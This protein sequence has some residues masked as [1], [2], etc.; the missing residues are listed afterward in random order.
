[1]KQAGFIFVFALALLS[2]AL[3][4]TFTVY[5]TRISAPVSADGLADGETSASSTNL[6]SLDANVYIFDGVAAPA[7]AVVV[8]HGFAESKDTL[9]IGAFAEDFAA[10]GYVVVTPSVRGFGNSDGLVSLVGPNEIN[11]LKSIILAMQTGSIGDSPAV[12][13][14]VTSQSKF[15]VMGDSYGRAHIL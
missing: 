10:A 8:V 3:G 12:V 9:A 14:P 4:G 11:D 7:P 13:I 5:S 1:M 2:R 6:I 15:G